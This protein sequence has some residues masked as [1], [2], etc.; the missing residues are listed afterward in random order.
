KQGQSMAPGGLAAYDAKT[1]LTGRR[2]ELSLQRHKG[3]DDADS[4]KRAAVLAR[5]RLDGF[6][7]KIPGPYR[8]PREMTRSEMI[9]KE[10]LDKVVET[11]SAEAEAANEELARIEKELT[12]TESALANFKSNAAVAIEELC[13][14]R[15]EKTASLEKTRTAIADLEGRLSAVYES[16]P[17]V[18]GI[19]SQR[20]DIL[21]RQVMGEK[22]LPAKMEALD[23]ELAGVESEREKAKAEADDLTAALDSLGQKEDALTMD[24]L[25]LAEKEPG[26]IQEFIVEKAKAHAA[27]YT[28]AAEAMMS[29]WRMLKGL[30][31]LLRRNGQPYGRLLSGDIEIP[32]IVPAGGGAYGPESGLISG[33][34]EIRRET[35]MEAIQPMLEKLRN[36]GI[37]I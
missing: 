12:N 3:R 28:K 31:D 24:L 27:E 20:A 36:E 14:E 19:E 11:S 33:P 29:W 8:E 23:K 34:M 10:R 21:S 6:L 7:R 26:I 30:E 15:K 32:R 25:A 2:D 37:N 9:E 13:A 5:A 18:A 22:I 16:A 35:H 17:D 4:R 1:E